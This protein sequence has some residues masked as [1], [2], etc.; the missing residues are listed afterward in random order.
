MNEYLFIE[1]SLH[2]KLQHRAGFLMYVKRFPLTCQL[3]LCY[4]VQSSISQGKTPTLGIKINFM[5]SQ[6]SILDSSSRAGLLSKPLLKPPPF[7]TEV[8]WRSMALKLV[9]RGVSRMIPR[10]EGGWAGLLHSIS[11]INKGHI[12]IDDEMTVLNPVE[13]IFAHFCKHPE[14]QPSI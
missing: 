6:L 14:V 9:L 1:S 12:A 7:M 10:R 11:W 3:H 2:K 13:V 8:L 5:F 4:N